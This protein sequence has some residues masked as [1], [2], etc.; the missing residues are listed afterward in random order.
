MDWTISCGSTLRLSESV[1]V[2]V[3]DALIFA[4]GAHLNIE[5]GQIITNQLTLPAEG[6]AVFTLP[7][8]QGPTPL[9]I[10]DDLQLGDENTLALSIPPDFEADRKDTFPLIEFSGNRTGSFRDKSE[11][12]VVEAD[13]HLF[14]LH[15]ELNPGVVGLQYLGISFQ[16]WIDGFSLPEN[17]TG[18][19]Q[20]P[21]GDRIPNL[22]KYVRGLSPMTPVGSQMVWQE[23]VQ[24]IGDTPYL[25]LE[26]PRNPKAPQHSIQVL[27]SEDLIH[28]EENPESVTVFVNAPE[29]F[30]ARLNLTNYTTAFLRLKLEMEE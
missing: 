25:I 1:H 28:W 27:V 17:Q 21:A 19:D 2:E 12:A 24:V 14:S 11:G 9:Q 20:D 8:T 13:G 26:M 22:I 30:Q 6:E 4:D 5:S 23:R 3:D 15:Y 18:P 7:I 16:K 29:M 10:N